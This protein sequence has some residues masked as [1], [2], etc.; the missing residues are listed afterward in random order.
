MCNKRIKYLFFTKLVVLFGLEKAERVFK[1]FDKR[2][3]KP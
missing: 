2:S 1:I 3:F